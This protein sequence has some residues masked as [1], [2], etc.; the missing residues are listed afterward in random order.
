[1]QHLKN[2]INTKNPGIALPEKL[3]EGHIPKP[4]DIYLNH[5]F[6]DSQCIIR[7]E[8]KKGDRWEV[9]KYCFTDE[10]F[11]KDYYSL[12]DYDLQSSN[13]RLLLHPL[14]DI[15]N[16]ADMIFKGQLPEEDALSDNT[17]LVRTG[18][19]RLLAL[20]DDAQMKA[21]LMQ[22]VKIVMQSR[23]N[24]IRDEMEQRMRMLEP[25]MDNLR[26]QT[27]ILE[28]VLSWLNAY[29][30][31]GVSVK[32]ISTGEGA[33]KN[34]PLTIRQRILYMDEEVAIIGNDGQ[35]LDYSGKETFYEWLKN[36]KHRDL[37]L[38][39]ER[40][41]VVMKPKRYNH[42]YTSNAYENQL[43]NK[44]NRHSFIMIRDGEN[45]HA[46]ESDEL[47]IFDAV[48]PTKLQYE[49]IRGDKWTNDAKKADQ[50]R[51][52]QGR[53]MFYMMLLQ[54]LTDNTEILGVHDEINLTKEI[55]VRIIL[56][57]EKDSMLGTGIKP[58]NQ[59]MKERQSDIKRGDRIIFR[60][61]WRND[62]TFYRKYYNEY[63]EPDRPCS[64]LYSVDE[65]EDGRLIFK[66]KPG[67]KVFNQSEGW[68]TERK[69]R[70]S[71]VFSHGSAINF[72]TTEL[73]DLEA[74]LKDRTQRDCYS[75]IVGLLVT[76]RDIKR[77][78][79]EMERHFIN[80]LVEDIAKR[81]KNCDRT[82]LEKTVKESVSWWKTKVIFKRPL[83]EDDAKAWRMIRQ[84]TVKEYN[85]IQ[86]NNQTKSNYEVVEK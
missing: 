79:A 63:S 17:D 5:T 25:V 31:K 33:S 4:G 70:V 39:E 86:R 48:I 73:E 23:M 51:R 43:I 41:A 69:N 8:N 64:G 29:L 75:G 74:Y 65:A 72:D 27:E 2:K 44:K 12:S 6:T 19:E 32:T 47:E 1:M 59:W 10:D 56:D 49:I 35:G 9:K 53:T 58:W 24:G 62:G 71:Y 38:P 84:K 15:L 46:I 20:M 16:Q 82:L 60:A 45:V 13:Y 78:E 80:L 28:Q 22:S 52:M 26:R 50:I 85:T 34:E 57:A 30:G 14:E 81:E 83:S 66:Y 61:S 67:D 40:C 54:G 11:T 37:I 42:H 7:L 77:K 68:Y 18:K 55:G 3:R 21:D 36:P 76:M